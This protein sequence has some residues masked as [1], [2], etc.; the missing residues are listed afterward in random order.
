MR[1]DIIFELNDGTRVRINTTYILGVTLAPANE[2]NEEEIRIL[3]HG[4][5]KYYTYTEN[6]FPSKK[7]W[8]LFCDHLLSIFS[9]DSL[10]NY[11][12]E[13]EV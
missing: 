13:P 6:H 3:F 7:A 12:E 2:K 9:A 11:P 10:I 8:K 5:A 4:D 1:G